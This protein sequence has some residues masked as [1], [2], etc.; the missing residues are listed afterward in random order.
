MVHKT[1]TLAYQTAALLL[2]L[3]SLPARLEGIWTEV[4]DMASAKSRWVLKT[5]HDGIAA[6]RRSLRVVRG[7]V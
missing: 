6:L 3:F 2:L 5:M 4:L 1:M 7:E